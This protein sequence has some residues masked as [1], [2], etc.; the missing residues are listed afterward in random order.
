MQPFYGKKVINEPITAT[1]REEAKRKAR[2][3]AAR[4]DEEFA[5]LKA[6]P[7]DQ[8]SEFI[9]AGGIAAVKA[10]YRALTSDGPTHHIPESYLLSDEPLEGVAPSSPFGREIRLGMLDQLR[11]QRAEQAEY[12][13]F[14]AKVRPLM[15]TAAA[16]PEMSLD[17]L[18]DLWVRCAPT[19]DQ[20]A[21]RRPCFRL[22]AKT[23]LRTVTAKRLFED[24][25][26]GCRL[27][28]GRHIVR[29]HAVVGA[30]GHK[31]AVATLILK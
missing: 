27:N 3:L 28:N 19:I 1:S 15:L 8:A 7:P 12:D 21:Q 22:H 6:L 14:I 13:K 30:H 10:K 25:R 23:V 16:A 18:F 17:G 11:E 29:L 2:A 24:F 4:Y 26:V 9:A 20:H 5:M 31:G